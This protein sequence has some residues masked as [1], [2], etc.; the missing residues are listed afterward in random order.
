MT[1]EYSAE[2]TIH[3]VIDNLG[4]AGLPEG[5]PEIN[6]ITTNGTVTIGDGGTQ[7]RYEE[8]GE[9]GRTSC[10]LRLSEDGAT[11]T[12]L[13]AIDCVMQ[14][15]EG[16]TTST[17]YK[18]PPYAFDMSLNAL[19]IRNEVGREGGDV[20]LIYLMSVGGQEKRARMK[21]SVRVK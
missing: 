19:R 12:R 9:G 5:E 18:I 17:V 3:S 21:I 15:K 20:R 7:I 11:L 6:L 2:L 14:F 4:E 13:G 1:Y 8:S 16:R 10:T